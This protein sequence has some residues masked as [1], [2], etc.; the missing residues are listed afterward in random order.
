MKVVVVFGGKSWEREGSLVSA[1]DVARSLDRLG[2]ENS[3]CE[4]D[5]DFAFHAIGSA[6]F[7]FN[8]IHG[9][10]GENGN[11]SAI[12]HAMGLP[13]NFSGSLAHSFSLD[14]LQMKAL[15]AM[16]AIPIPAV[17]IGTFDSKRYAG[18]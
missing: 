5:R 4:F 12:C 2:I 9:G 11:L 16:R 8:T 10:H 1:I 14:K 7:V 18:V 6:D 17:V 3:L 15:A 13:C